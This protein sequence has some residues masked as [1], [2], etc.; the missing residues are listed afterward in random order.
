[1]S[2]VIQTNFGCEIKQRELEHTKQCKNCVRYKPK[3]STFVLIVEVGLN[4][5]NIKF[6]VRKI[7]EIDEMLPLSM[8][9][10][11]FADIA[12]CTASY[13]IPLS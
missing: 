6:C 3:F 1:M 10:L 2:E 5:C 7:N 13:D 4:V 12:L 9:R 8:L 11:L